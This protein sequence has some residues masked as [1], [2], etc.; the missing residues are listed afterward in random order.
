[1]LIL[2]IQITDKTLK[3]VGGV[4]GGVGGAVAAAG[5]VVG[6]S[7]LVKK[8]ASG[9]IHIFFLITNF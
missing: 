8:Q 2:L 4:L 5:L 3:I 7:K 6:G 9:K 1:M